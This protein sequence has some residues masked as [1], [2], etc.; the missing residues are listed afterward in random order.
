MSLNLIVCGFLGSG[1]TTLIRRIVCEA[2]SEHRVVVVENE[3]GRESV[4]GIFLREGGLQVVELRAGCVCC[5]L[6]SEMAEAMAHVRA[7]FEPECVV[8]EPSGLGNLADLLRIPGFEP[9]GV[10]MLVDVA[11]FDLLLKLNRDHYLRQ[12]RLAPVLV[13]THTDRAAPQQIARVRGE[14]E[15]INP[16]ALIV[17]GRD[18]FD[19]RWWLETVPGRYAR[20]RAF[21]PALPGGGPRFVSETFPVV[22]TVRPADLGELFERLERQSLLPVRAKGCLRGDAGWMKADWLAPRELECAPIAEPSACGGFL[23][24]WWA[25]SGEEPAMLEAVHE[26]LNDW[27]CA[28]R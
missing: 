27:N 23:T 5:S 12:F 7:D 6:R 26:L 8:L 13:L 24:C 14:L 18:A 9:D 2:L 11:R 1:K 28:T 10:V 17:E 25:A 22:R 19:A 4:D 16:G 3:S 20:F 15:R 21:A